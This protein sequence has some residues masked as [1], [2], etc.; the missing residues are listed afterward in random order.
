MSKLTAL[1][2]SR[3]SKR[4]LYGDGGGLYLQITAAGV[5]SW[6]FRY[7]DNGRLRNHGLGPLGTVSL[8]E[9]REAALECRKL[10]LQGIDPIEAKKQK[11]AA[12]KLEAAK[13]ITFAE[14]ANAYIEA[15]RTGWKNAKHVYQWEMSLGKHAYPVFG[16]L[17]VAAVDAPL[18]LRALEPIWATKN[19]TA[20][21]LRGRIERVLDWAKVRG[22]RTGENPAAWKGNL[23]H[24]LP[25]P[26]RVA[27]VKHHPALPHA[28][29]SAFWSDLAEHTSTSAQALRFAILTA[30][31]TGEVLGATWDE[32][33]LEAAVWTVPAER[34]KIR[35]EHRVPLPPTAVA[36]L[37]EQYEKRNG[38]YIFPG[39]KPGCT[40]SNMALLTLLRRM[41][42]N[43][44]TVHGFRSTFRDWAAECTDAP[45]E[46]PE[47]ALAHT[48]SNQV[49]AAYRRTD[50]FEKRRALM[51]EWAGYCEGVAV[52]D[53][54]KTGS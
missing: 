19:E 54:T 24:T 37:K 9:A 22:Y 28:Q 38:D 53:T 46:V 45:R 15:H 41:K 33:D 10:R 35:K 2:I 32:V 11:R 6:I 1:Q 50:L 47:V 20:K 13:S 44:L 16:D 42:R 26:K 25:A 27:Q 8:A 3:L 31:R 51:E 30:A 36:L 52:C 7:R 17:P 49:E 18:V 5:K 34:M 43:E 23:A 12:E 14:C 40:L 39:A 21:R 4:G 29:I 48:I